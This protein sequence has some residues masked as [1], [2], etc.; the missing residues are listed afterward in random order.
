M[1]S[2]MVSLAA[3]VPHEDAE[4][5][6]SIQIEGATTPSDK[7]RA[8]IAEARR[9]HQGS[10]DYTVCL[11]QVNSMLAGFNSAARSAELESA[12]HSELVTR[13]L[14]WLPDMVAYIL[15]SQP[16]NNAY[17]VSTE[18]LA[19]IEKGIAERIFRL[20]ESV[21][22][23]GVTRQCPCYD[24]DAIITRV[25]PV[26]ELARVVQTAHGIGEEENK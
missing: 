2:K 13:T 25:S 14:D 15:S 12:T 24:K 16:A 19:Q 10:T 3:R 18:E 8:I 6:S 17:A 4:F 23:M 5:I 22:Q 1:S 11:E 7:V 9:R 21:L 26:L 20:M